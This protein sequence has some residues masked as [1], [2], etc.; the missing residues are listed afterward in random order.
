[1]YNHAG[2]LYI[3]LK[4]SIDNKTRQFL[5]I[6][7][8]KHYPYAVNVFRASAQFLAVGIYEYEI[9]LEQHKYCLENGIY[10]GYSVFCDNIYGITEIDV[11]SWKIEELN[12]FN[13]KK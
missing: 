1:M 9:L 2:N 6:A 4:K 12:F 3:G 11:P 10:E 8:E 13:S 7:Q 5:F